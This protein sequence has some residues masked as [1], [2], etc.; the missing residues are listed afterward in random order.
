MR[1][2]QSRGDHT[3]FFKHSVNGKVTALLDYVDDIIVTRDE[4][5]EH[6]VLRSKLAQNFEIKD[7]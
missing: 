1:Y 4:V 2:Q 5:E 7:L 6:K 3:I